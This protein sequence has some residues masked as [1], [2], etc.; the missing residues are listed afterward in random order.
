L[1]PTWRHSIQGR[2]VALFLVLALG[3]AAVFL[4]G[5]Q[6]LLHGGWQNYARPLVAD[7]VDR[8]AAQIG[9]PPDV[10]R[11]QALTQALP[12]TVRIEGPQVQFDSH[13]G[14]R[15]HR[16]DPQR[17]FGAAGWGLVRSTADGHRL[18]FRPGRGAGRLAPTPLRLDHAGRAAAADRCGLFRR[19]AHP[20]AAAAH[21]RW[22]GSLWRRRFSR[23]IRVERPDELGALAERINGMAT[24]LS[25]MLDAK[26]TLLLAISHELR[27]PLTRARVNAELLDDSPER[28]ALM[29]DLAEMGD[30]ISSLLESER[31]A[32]GHRALHAEATDLPALARDVVDGLAPPMAVTLQLASVPPKLVDPAPDCACCCA[33]CS[34]TRGAMPPGPGRRRRSSCATT[35]TASSRWA[36]ATTALAYPRPSS[37]RW[38]RPSTGPTAPARGKVAASA[39]GCTFA[40]WWPRLTAAN[41]SCAT[42]TQGWKWRCGGGRRRTESQAPWSKSGLSPAHFPVVSACCPSNA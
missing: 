8:L 35:P 30:L 41:C 20:Q 40:G 36:C 19:A 9:S 12:I 7:Y 10:Q 29:R 17:D 24:N 22:C 13:P 42:P 1:K 6:Q 14:R 11:A 15:S 2:L 23:A 25:G 33:T 18:S 28:Q 26:R 5:M 4:L 31:L 32:A 16:H 21:Q 38:P 37:R 39:W 3:T 34:K 27:S